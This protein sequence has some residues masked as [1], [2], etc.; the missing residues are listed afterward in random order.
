[1]PQDQ[2]WPVSVADVRVTKAIADVAAYLMVTNVEGIRHVAAAVAPIQT[3]IITRLLEESG[4]GSHAAKVPALLRMRE[5]AQRL[6]VPEYTAR[7]LG[8]GGHLPVVHLG[9]R[10]RVR[11]RDLDH[12][13]ELRGGT[14]HG[15]LEALAS[16][17]R[18]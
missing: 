9:R 13:I 8:R 11:E 2:A 3:L 10:V 14:G 6:G 18:R 15:P 17:S 12:F 1:M 7:E 4:S 16:R 5:V